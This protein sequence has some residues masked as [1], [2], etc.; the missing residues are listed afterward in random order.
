MRREGLPTPSTAEFSSSKLIGLRCL[1]L[2][3]GSTDAATFDAVFYKSIRPKNSVR[4]I[5]LFKT[6]VLNVVQGHGGP[7]ELIGACMALCGLFSG[8]AAVDGGAQ[9]GR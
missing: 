9:F 8:N 6:C 2:G 4:W 7:E 5:C 1:Y 3:A